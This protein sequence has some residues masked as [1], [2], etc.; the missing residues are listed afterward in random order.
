MENGHI[1]FQH[2]NGYLDRA[3]AMDAEEFFEARNDDRRGRWR[4]PENP[5]LVVYPNHGGGQVSV[6]DERDG[7]HAHYSRS[8]CASTTPSRMDGMHAAAHAYFD[9]HPVRKPWQDAKE[10]EGWIVTIGGEERLATVQES[11]FWIGSE[12]YRQRGDDITAARKIWPEDA[13]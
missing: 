11:Y 5:D 13:S 8:L 3:S 12:A 9:A 4:W 10:G 7:S 2:G 1:A 6:I